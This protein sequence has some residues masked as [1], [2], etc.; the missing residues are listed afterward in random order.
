MNKVSLVLK[1]TLN[2]AG[3][4]VPIRINGALKTGC[5]VGITTATVPSE[6]GQKIAFT[7]NYGTYNSDSPSK[8][9]KSDEGFSIVSDGTGSEMQAA[10]GLVGATGSSNYTAYDYTFSF[11]VQ[12]NI[13]VVKGQSKTI[14]VTPAI[15]RNENTTPATTKT[16]TYNA[17]NHKLYD[18]D[19]LDPSCSG[20]NDASVVLS[21]AIYNGDVLVSDITDKIS[22]GSGS[23]IKIT[24]PSM[25]Y[26]D[27]YIIKFHA[28]FLN[29][30]HEAT[31]DFV[32]VDSES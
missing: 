31:I 23:V 7:E 5:D 14:S 11:E 12:N 19:V 30:V 16:L 6:I 21:A 28:S 17:S 29:R 25:E 8:Y 18:G 3:I 13:E 24:I 9:F 2:K 20:S 1:N 4:T 27:S 15:T 22:A 32:V 10:I 26:E